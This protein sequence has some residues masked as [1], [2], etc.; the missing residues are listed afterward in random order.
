MKILVASVIT[1]VVTVE[2]LYRFLSPLEEVE[3][4]LEVLGV[5]ATAGAYLVTITAGMAGFFLLWYW[6]VT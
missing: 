1:L 4:R 2:L 3:S 5:L 6:A